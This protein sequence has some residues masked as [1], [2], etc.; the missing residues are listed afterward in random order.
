MMKKGIEFNELLVLILLLAL[1][2]MLYVVI[3]VK[4]GYLVK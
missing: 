3:V 4:G 1:M 2:V